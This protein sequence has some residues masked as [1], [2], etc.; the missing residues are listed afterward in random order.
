M[1]LLAN[2]PEVG[3]TLQNKGSFGSSVWL[4]SYFGTLRSLVRIQSPR[5]G[6]NAESVR[7][8]GYPPA[9]RSGRNLRSE[10]Y[11][12]IRFAAQE[13]VPMPITKPERVPKYRR[14]IRPGARDA[15]FV[16]IDGGR[17]HLGPL[18]TP[19]SRRHPQPLGDPRTPLAHSPTSGSVPQQPSAHRRTPRS[20]PRNQPSL[21]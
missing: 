10:T 16:E 14:Q 12:C 17:I 7:L 9:W 5:F 18:G 2:S 3:Y 1:R 15:A 13:A 8:Y 19:H 6:A 21:H 11:L 20:Q 4:W